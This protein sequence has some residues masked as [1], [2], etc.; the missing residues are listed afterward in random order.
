MPPAPAPVGVGLDSAAVRA[1]MVQ[2][3]AAGGITS[4]A[5]L[6]AMGTVERHRFVD[7]ALVNQAYED[8]S[9]PIGL[10]QT[11]SKPSV[12]A[13]MCELLLGAE[14]AR[15][16]LGRVLEIGTGC[17]YQA[18]VLSLLAREVYTLERLRGLHDKAR[19]HLRP[20]RLA[21]VHLLFG[22]GTLGYAKGAPYAAIIAAAGGD[23]VPQAWCDQLAVGGRLVA[24]MAVAGGQQ[25][26][27]V[28]DKTPHGLKQNVLEPVHFVPLK[29]GIA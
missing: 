18:A 17:G 16:G 22:D 4:P 21:N 3:L 27:L 20:F 29:S 26:L 19:H 8:T 13:R 5:V 24:P 28:I 15:G 23:A 10:G 1:R 6:Q 11:I 9:L 12:V 7:S 25:V 14:A 2:K